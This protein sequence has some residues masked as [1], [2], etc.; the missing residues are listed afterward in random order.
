MDEKLN[1]IYMKQTLMNFHL[2]L[3]FRLTNNEVFYI[4]INISLGMIFMELL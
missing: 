2:S 1:L 3:L 4:L